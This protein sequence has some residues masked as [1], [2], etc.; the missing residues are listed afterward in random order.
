MPRQ[1][2][3]Q[4]L[5]G[6]SEAAEAEFEAACAELIRIHYPDAKRVRVHRGDGGVDTANGTWGEAGALDVFQVKYF[7]DV[8]GNSQRQQIRE[9]YLTAANN[10]NFKMRSWKLCLPTILRQ[11]D[12]EWFDTWSGDQETHIELWDG[13]KLEALLRQPSAGATRERLKALG[14]VGLLASAP[15]LRPVLLARRCDPLKGTGFFLQIDLFNHGD[16]AADNVRGTL[17]HTRE[18]QHRAH[19]PLSPWQHENQELNPW[20]VSLPRAMTP[21]EHLP[22]MQ[23]PFG[24]QAPM[25]GRVELKIGS[26]TTPTRTWYAEAKETDI[27]G[28]VQIEFTPDTPPWPKEEPKAK[29]DEPQFDVAQQLLESILA[30]PDPE[31]QGLSVLLR[32]PPGHIG[33]TLYYPNT[34]PGGPAP[35]IDSEDL[36]QAV[37]ELVSLGWLNLR[38]SDG[39]REVY[40]LVKQRP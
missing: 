38:G 39:A 13:D 6:V 3:F 11:E 26:R 5:R 12:H 30:N 32:Q 14:V 34:G 9:S 37:L 21:G 28:N 27:T 10:Q 7:P 19:S 36:R 22:V 25:L 20:V 1:N 2:P 17:S 33:R 16:A 24:A 4:Q 31:T 23:I 8:L 15:D 40:A 35:A 29:S 18:T